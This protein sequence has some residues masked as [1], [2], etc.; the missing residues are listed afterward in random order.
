MRAPL[1]S[2]SKVMPFV[3]FVLG[4]FAGCGTASKVST[5]EARLAVVS[6]KSASE[7]SPRLKGLMEYF[8][9]DSHLEYCMFSEDSSY[10]PPA[11]LRKKWLLGRATIIVK[12]QGAHKVESDKSCG[13]PVFDGSDVPLWCSYGEAYRFDMVDF[14]RN[15]NAAG[16]TDLFGGRRKVDAFKP[17]TGIQLDERR[18][19]LIFSE[20]S[21]SAFP[22]TK[23]AKLYI[24][25]ACDMGDRQIGTTR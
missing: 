16:D 21:P 4:L 9:D 14:M 8:L 11:V 17:A 1:H 7:D 15:R 13:L 20:P 10:Y 3:T 25:A 19:Y 6:D 18:S 2:S 24:T 22:V 23:N 12:V 5:N